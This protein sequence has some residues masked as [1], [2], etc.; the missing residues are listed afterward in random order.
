MSDSLLGILEAA[1]GQGGGVRGILMS[2]HLCCGLVTILLSCPWRCTEE[3]THALPYLKSAKREG[4]PKHIEIQ[5]SSFYSEL[6]GQQWFQL[7]FHYCLIKR[8]LLSVLSWNSLNCSLL[9]NW[10]LQSDSSLSNSALL[11]C[12]LQGALAPAKAWVSK[13]KVALKGVGRGSP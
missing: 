10:L 12:L 11:L 1:C 3:Q 9:G 5:P 13:N 7:I 6:Q 8:G 2:A 4:S